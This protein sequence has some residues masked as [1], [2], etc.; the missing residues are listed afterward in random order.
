MK[1]NIL[2]NNIHLYRYEFYKK[3]Y[4]CVFIVVRI[5]QLT[6]IQCV[7]DGRSGALMILYHRLVT[8]ARCAHCQHSV[9]G[10]HIF[11]VY[12]H[13]VTGAHFFYIPTFS[14]K[15]THYIP[16]FRDRF[17]HYFFVYQHSVTGA[18][19]FYIPTFSDR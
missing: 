16:T 4:M 14:D 10:A 3:T 1:Y 12:Q 8:G 13:S 9:T 6:T 17:T 2:C 5:Y 19:F 15:C 18:H 7:Y 11:F